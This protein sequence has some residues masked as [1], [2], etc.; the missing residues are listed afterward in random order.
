MYNACYGVNLKFWRSVARTQH[1][2][3]TKTL[4]GVNRVEP[5]L[6]QIIKNPPKRVS[7]IHFRSPPNLQA[8]ARNKVV[9]PEN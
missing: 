4:G 7:I 5:L 3:I 1:Y 6:V 9:L 2:Y 8:S